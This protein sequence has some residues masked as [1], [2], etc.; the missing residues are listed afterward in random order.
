MKWWKL[1]VGLV[2][3]MIGYVTNKWILIVAGVVLLIIFELAGTFL[4]VPEGGKP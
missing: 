2:I 1:S 3:S 4:E